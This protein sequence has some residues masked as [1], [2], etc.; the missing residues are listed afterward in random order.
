[1]FESL[2]VAQHGFSRRDVHR[3]YD[4][5]YQTTGLVLPSLSEES[6]CMSAVTS[7]RLSSSH[8]IDAS[9]GQVEGTAPI[10]PSTSSETDWDN[11]TQSTDV[12]SDRGDKDP[13]P[14]LILDYVRGEEMRL[15]SP[16]ASLHRQEHASLLF[17]A[18][19]GLDGDAAL[20][21]TRSLRKEYPAWTIRVA[22]FHPSWTSQQRL[23]ASEVILGLSTTEM[24][25]SVGEDGEVYV[26][27]IAL[28]TAPSDRAAF[29]PTRPWTSQ[30]G[31]IVQCHA[32]LALGDKRVVR[33]SAIHPHAGHV[34]AFAGTLEGSSTVVVGLTTA[35]ICSH[36][37]VHE[38]SVV[39]YDRALLDSVSTGPSL[40]APSIAALLVGPPNLSNPSRL[41]GKRVLIFSP[42]TSEE[43]LSRDLQTALATLPMD[44][45]FLTSLEGSLLKPIYA[46]K[47]DFI[48]SGTCDKHHMATLQDILSPSGRALFWNDPDRGVAKLLAED[49]WI[50]G[51][52]VR[53]SLDYHR[54]Q[55]LPDIVYTSLLASL[56]DI[57]A[58]KTARLPSLF[59][60]HK[61]YLLVGGIGS[62]GL[63]IALWMYNVSSSYVYAM[64]IKLTRMQHGARNLILTS[65]SGVESLWTRGD[66]IGK[67]I[68]DY[69]QSREDLAIQAYAASATSLERLEAILQETPVPLGGAI[70]LS[71]LLND[72]PFASQ[73]QDNFDSVFPPKVDAFTTL[74]RAVDVV[75]L[76]FCVTFSS[77]SG[78][79]GNPGQTSYAAYV[80]LN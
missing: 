38:D 71:A 12:S 50:V 55:Q 22:V 56:G 11:T 49:P 31:D 72:C 5:V 28:S 52:A 53:A 69:L 35:P 77:I 76:N 79:F 75:S 57:D 21:F 36:L 4:V 27:R 44:V 64:A 45:T 39:A 29:D 26:P 58:N 74:T 73:D 8:A 61:A 20:G 30:N 70:I 2:E 16:I 18:D 54:R 43:S 6:P 34:W 46:Q 62:L 23:Y 37:V 68:L 47:P 25:M 33:V 3:R 42:S 15:Q 65:R 66:F 1:M 63:H 13:F 51:D 14:N 24:E 9:E 10:S 67:R 17:V 7:A 78:M 41:R 40:L 59:N 60:P 19:Q 32:P 80:H 48:V